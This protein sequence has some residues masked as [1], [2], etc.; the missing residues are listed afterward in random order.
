MQIIK[1]TNSDKPNTEKYI[2]K[3]NNQEIGFGYLIETE[4]N[5][6]E[7]FINEDQRSNGYG[8][9][10][11]AKL[12]QICKEKGLKVLFFELKNEDYRMIIIITSLGAR[13][14]GTNYGINKFVLPV[15]LE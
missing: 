4:I 11:F 9:L 8:K 2:M 7:I 14:I 12:L 5:P 1:C 10:L 3:I 15:N 6:I 13:H